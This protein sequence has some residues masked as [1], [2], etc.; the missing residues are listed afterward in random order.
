MDYIS[1]SS[2][3]LH[4]IMKGRDHDATSPLDTYRG[5]SSPIDFPAGI[6]G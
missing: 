4:L 2:F 3:N 1:S 6:N 5:T